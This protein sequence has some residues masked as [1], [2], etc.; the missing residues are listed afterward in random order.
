MGLSSDMQKNSH[1]ETHNS[2][3]EEELLNLSLAFEY[4]K[5]FLEKIDKQID[6]LN[7][8][9]TTFLG[10]GGLLLRFSLELPDGCRSCVLLKVVVMLLT[11]CSVCISSYGL[12][13]NPMGTTVKPSVL[14]SDQWFGENNAEVKAKIT[15]TWLKGVQQLEEAGNRKQKQLNYAIRLLG[16]AV[17]TFA[18]NGIIS[19]LFSECT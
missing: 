11:A 7:S 16:I 9:L 5:D 15:S 1:N 12:L 2:A 14:M 10:F 6:D 3:S 4:T 17:A 18:I 8:R 13:A 19:T